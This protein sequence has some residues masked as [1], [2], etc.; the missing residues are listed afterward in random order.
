M[1][2]NNFGIIVTEQLKKSYDRCPH[3]SPDTIREE[4]IS[5]NDL[6]I[7]IENIDHEKRK[8]VQDFIQCL[9]T[10]HADVRKENDIVLINRKCQKIFCSYKQDDLDNVDGILDEIKKAKNYLI[11]L[12]KEPAANE[13]VKRIGKELFKL[14]CQIVKDSIENKLD[15]ENVITNLI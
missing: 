6:L 14:I 7:K 12:I 15:F 13:D 8:V 10:L 1:S 2:T 5:N 11:S 3:Q 4:D 9:V